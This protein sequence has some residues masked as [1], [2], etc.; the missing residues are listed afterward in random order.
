LSKERGFLLGNAV[1]KKCC[2]A[3]ISDVNL[4]ILIKAN[5]IFCVIRIFYSLLLFVSTAQLLSQ[6]DSTVTNTHWTNQLITLDGGY[7]QRSDLVG[8][9]ADFSVNYIFNPNNFLV[10]LKYGY[11][12][13]PTFDA[14]HKAYFSLGFTTRVSRKF[15]WQ[16]VMGAGIT[17]KQKQRARELW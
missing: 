9:N 16:I 4:I 10:S 6:K 8:T 7:T 2:V 12:P 15:S 17:G 1:R 3:A 5:L 11:V 13:S 14:I